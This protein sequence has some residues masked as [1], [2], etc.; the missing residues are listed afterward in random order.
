MLLLVTNINIFLVHTNGTKKKAERT[1]IKSRVHKSI[2]KRQKG[3]V[4]MMDET[5]SCTCTASWPSSSRY[6]LNTKEGEHF[7]FKYLALTRINRFSWLRWNWIKNLK[8]KYIN[9]CDFILLKRERETYDYL[10]RCLTVTYLSYVFVEW[11]FE[12]EIKER[13]STNKK[14]REHFIRAVIRFSINS[15]EERKKVKTVSSYPT[16][17]SPWILMW[18]KLEIGYDFSFFSS[19]FFFYA[20]QNCNY[21][22]AEATIVSIILNKTLHVRIMAA[23]ISKS[24][25][26]RVS[27]ENCVW[28]VLVE[29]KRQ[30]L[31]KSAGNIYVWK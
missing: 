30:E 23:L 13:R 28:N 21:F 17:L 24:S 3:R 15:I 1:F 16:T 26:L 14:K 6:N 25:E 4:S 10:H 19:F 27:F 5:R 31:C 29:Q 7:T 22:H 2:R 9:I 20:W 11:N 12:K 18:E 8:L